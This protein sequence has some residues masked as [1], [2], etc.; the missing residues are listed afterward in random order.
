MP[1]KAQRA[2]KYR[3]FPTDSQREQLAKTF[4][5]ARFVYNWALNMRTQA[6][7]QAKKSLSYHTTATLQTPLKQ[8]PQTAF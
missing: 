1:V 2:Y 5:C 4:G 3:F 7:Q 8:Q 6:W